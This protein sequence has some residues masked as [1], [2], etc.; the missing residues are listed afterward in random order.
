[1]SRTSEDRYAYGRR[2]GLTC[3]LAALALPL[4]LGVPP[5]VA[6]RGADGNFEKRTSSHF[7]LYQ[8]VDIDESHGLRGSRRFEQDVLET[9]EDAYDGL[10]RFLGLRPR[11]MIS[12]TIYD[13]AV[14]DAQF[15]GLFRFPSAGFYGDSIHVRGTTRVTERLVRVLH[16]EVVHAAFDATAPS[17]GLPA[18]LNEGVAEWFEARSVG[19]RLLSAGEYQYLAGAA[20]QGSL[21]SLSDMSAP[22]FGRF[23]PQAAQLA[24]LQSY[25]FIV[26][27]VRNHGER[28]LREFCDTFLRVRNLERSARRTYRVGLSRLEERFAG[29]LRGS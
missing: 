23:G 6:D 25:A 8:D 19:K 5:A 16:H 1:M 14:F 18:W 27:L 21:L 12:V 11:R 9:L 3:L 20:Q 13:P 29:E 7:V 10:D 22:S 2:A 24:Y 4:L 17:L 15:T 28:S 26:F